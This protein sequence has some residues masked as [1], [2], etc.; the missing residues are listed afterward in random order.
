MP[1]TDRIPVT[2]VGSLARP[3][4]LME[5]V[6]AIREEKPYD[7]AALDACLTKSVAEVV[8]HQAEVGVDV[9]S[10]GEFGKFRTWSSYVISRLSGYEERQVKSFVGTGKDQ[11]RFPEFYAEYFPS[12]NLPMRGQL[13]CVAPLKYTGQVELQRDI[14]NFKAALKQTPGVEGFLPVV[15]PAS[16]APHSIDEH[17]GSE[18]DYLFGLAEALRTEYQTVVDAGLFVQ[19][20]DAFLPYMYDVKFADGPMADYLE[21]A[22]VRIAALNH[23]LEGIPQD[24]VR[25]HICWGSF[26]TPHTSDVALRDIAALVLKVKAGAFCLEMANPRHEHEWKVFKDVKLPAGKKLIPGVV[27]HATN[28]VE[29]PELVAERLERLAAVVGKENVLAGTDCGFAQSPFTNRVHP[30]IAWAKLQALSEGA[31]LASKRLWGK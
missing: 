9:V 30:S 29:H 24:K 22:E 25:Y 12:Q 7:E 1:P 17:Y 31:A 11:S 14:D 19:V 5:F 3:P 8:R 10:D 15:A 20:D 23:A 26:N 16:A 13:A 6:W 28:I 27:G 21:W 2:H 18:R 4:E